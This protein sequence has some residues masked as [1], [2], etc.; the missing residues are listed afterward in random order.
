MSSALSPE[1]LAALEFPEVIDQIAGQA[2]CAPG[3]AAV[4]D[5]SPLPDIANAQ[6]EQLLVEDAAAFVQAGGSI[7][8]GGSVDVVPMLERAALGASLSGTDLRSIADAERALAACGR[9]KTHSVLRPSGRFKE[10]L[11]RRLDTF[12]LVARIDRAV[13]PDGRIADGASS[14]LSKIRRQQRALQEEVR[15]RCQAL[16][17]KPSVAKLL[18]EAVVT[19]REGR[20]VLPVRREYVAQFEG[21]VHDESASGAT[22][23]IEPMA[24]VDANNRLRS[25]ESAEEREIARILAELS[26][27]VGDDSDALRA[28]AALLARVDCV[29]ARA[30]WG[31]ARAA[32]RPDLGEDRALRIVAGRHPLLRREVQPLDVDLGERFDALIISGPNMGGKSVALKTIGL[33]CVLAYAGIPLPAAPGTRFG[34]FEHVAC[35]LGDEQSIADDLSSFSAHLQALR[36]ALAVAGPRSLVLVDEIGSGTEPSAGAALA[37]AFVEA[38]LARGARAV[39]TTHFTQLKVF[40]AAAE[41]VTNA[42]MLFDPE[43]NA[44]TYVLAVGVPGQSLA[45]PLAKALK[46]DPALIARAE[47]LLGVEARGL[48]RAFEELAAERDAMR[49]KQTELEAERGRSQELEAELARQVEAAAKERK[50]FELRAAGVL[51]DAVRQVRAELVESALRSAEVTRRKKAPSEAGAG[52]ALEKTLEGMRKSLGLEPSAPGE[53]GGPDFKAGDTVFVRSFDASGVIRELYER[54]ALVAMGGVKVVVSRSELS[55]QAG[56]PVTPARHATMEPVLT[57]APSSIDVRGMRV[58]EAMPLV[59]KAL[60]SASLAGAAELRIIHGKGTGQ[61]GR[62]IRE[63][64]R[65]HPQVATTVQAGDREGGSG[66]TIV[67]LK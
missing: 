7:A 9:A 35:V 6:T 52:K 62:G 3:E 41:R 21:V 19:V 30:R 5:L 51:H 11:G 59:D 33:F 53:S 34:R 65:D 17:R 60:D 39:V 50:Q 67:S 10:L 28:N 32:N 66:V 42:S 45:F 43:T 4:R 27:A 25:L 22:A 26:A 57:D 16:V 12:A 64:L 46:L 40:A 48:E 18:S 55:A 1:T 49:R 47:E 14:E 56:K 61:L 8:F 58:D 36:G 54:D 24:C 31:L 2:T 13:E 15:E 20:Y 63:F 23:Y 29:G 37:Q 44:P 38:L